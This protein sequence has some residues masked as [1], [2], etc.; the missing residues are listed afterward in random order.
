[1]SRKIRDDQCHRCGAPIL[2]GYDGDVAGLFAQLEAT[3]VKA[4]VEAW[5]MLAGWDTY[6]LGRGGIV[7][8]SHWHIA[9]NSV[10]AIHVDHRCGHSV[11][12]RWQ[13]PPPPAPHAAIDPASVP[14]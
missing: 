9:A 3:P 2:T 1:M 5:L 10:D 6:W 13:I 4:S 14:F 11:P 7:N 8:R 12:H